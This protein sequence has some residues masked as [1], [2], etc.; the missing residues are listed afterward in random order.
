MAREVDP[1][2]TRKALR[3]IR[4]LAA[5]G[6]TPETIDPETGEAKSVAVFGNNVWGLA[7]DTDGQS[8]LAASVGDGAQVARI[9]D[10]QIETW[11]REEVMGARG[12]AVLP[13]GR[14]LVAV[15]HAGHS[16][17]EIDRKSHRPT[18]LATLSDEPGGI[19]GML[20]AESDGNL[21]VGMYLSDAG[22]VYRFDVAQ[23]KFA[24]LSSQGHLAH[25][26]GVAVVPGG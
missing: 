4:K 6:G 5:K 8:L 18:R 24:L 21:I 1:K 12:I 14:V 26:G 10:G 3:I 23:R 9:H 17:V 15:S 16:M 25:C 7:V 22:H 20:A 2:Q 13:G 19:L 11:A